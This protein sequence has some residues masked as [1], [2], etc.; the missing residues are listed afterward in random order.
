MLRASL[1]G[2]WG[3]PLFES[4]AANGQKI[5]KSFS[6]AF[7]MEYNL[8]NCTIVAFVYDADTREVLQAEEVKIV[9]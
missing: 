4:S 7:N 6:A 5:L 1:N 3:D 9:K 8:L 2:T